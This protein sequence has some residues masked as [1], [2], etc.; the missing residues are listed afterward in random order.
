MIGRLR[1][2]AKFLVSNWRRL[3]ATAISLAVVVLVGAAV[4]FFWPH[5]LPE[6]AASPSQPQGAD[7]VARGKHLTI[8]ADCEACHT[9]PGGKPFVG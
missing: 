8:A 7:L 6:V 9:T 4:F 2:V 1:S 5:S 3:V